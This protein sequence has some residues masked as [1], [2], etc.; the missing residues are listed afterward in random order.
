MNLNITSLQLAA[1]VNITVS[2]IFDGNHYKKL[3]R[4]YPNTSLNSI[5]TVFHTDV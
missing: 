4:Q 2:Q 1:C 5:P 3:S